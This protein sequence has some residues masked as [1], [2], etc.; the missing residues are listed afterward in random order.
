MLYKKLVVQRTPSP[1]YH[2]LS[3]TEQLTIP[4]NKLHCSERFSFLS[5]LYSF[6]SFPYFLPPLH[7][8]ISPIQNLAKWQKPTKN[9]I[10]FFLN[11]PITVTY[12]CSS[13]TNSIYKLNSSIYRKRKCWK[14][15]WKNLWNS[16]LK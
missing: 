8:S 11:W 5:L 3:P 4:F 15:V 16:K 10:P 6:V 1:L 2:R 9:W 12:T 7:Y 13:L 14:L